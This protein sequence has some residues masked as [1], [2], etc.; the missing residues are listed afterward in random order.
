VRAPRDTAQLI[1]GGERLG[2]ELEDGY[3]IAPTV[4]GDVDNSSPLAQE[5]IFG[6]VLAIIPFDDDEAVRLANGTPYGLAAYIHTRD[7]PRAH[8]LAAQLQAGNVSVN[9]SLANPISAL[10]GGVKRSGYGRLGGLDGLREFSRPKNVWMAMWSRHGGARVPLFDNKVAVI[11]GAARGLGRDYA[12]FFAADGATVVI[13]DIGE[14]GAKN[15]AEE[16]SASG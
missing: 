14:A 9:G 6:P 13:A 11:T 15:A 16:L 2:G 5:E 7:L 4:F 12:A 1:T 8:T 10:F 3:F